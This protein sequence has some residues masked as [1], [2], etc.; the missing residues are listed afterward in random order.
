MYEIETYKGLE[1][2]EKFLEVGMDVHFGCLFFFLNLQMDL[3]KDTRNSL[4][5]M[6]L[7]QNIKSILVES[8]KAIQHYT[9]LQTEILKR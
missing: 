2:S 3:M 8:G 1:K 5:E 9:N 6:E 7:P 4:T